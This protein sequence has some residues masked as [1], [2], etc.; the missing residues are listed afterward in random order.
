MRICSV[1]QSFYPYIGGVSSYLFHLAK[2]INKTDHNIQIVSLNFDDSPLNE[3]VHDINVIR[4]NYYHSTSNL[5]KG[6]ASFKEILLKAF[7]GV[8]PHNNIPVKNQPGFKEYVLLNNNIADTV[9]SLYN[10][11]SF[12]IIHVHD[13]QLLPLG[14]LL[15]NIPV[16]IIFT[17]H[18]PFLEITPKHWITFSINYLD[19]FDHIIVSSPNY[20]NTLLNNGLSSH[21]ITSITPFIPEEKAQP[22]KFSKK[23]DLVTSKI[24]ICVA[25]IDPL[26]G[27][28]TLIKSIPLV[29]KEIPNVKFV[30]IGNGS[31]TKEILNPNY[32]NMFEKTLKK[33]VSD[34]NITDSV[35]FTGA[36]SRDEVVNAFH[37]CDIVV[38]PSLAEG[39]GLSITEGMSFGKPVIGSNVGGIPLQ[40]KNGINGYLIKPGNHIQLAHLLIHLLK[41]DCLIDKF[42]TASYLNY[43]NNFNLEKGLNSILNLYRSTLHNY[44]D[45]FSP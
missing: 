34:L 10:D 21:K 28:D 32:K 44:S 31:L 37:D 38:L 20:M 29:I 26:K 39:F 17:W 12:D 42:G 36:L 23:Y 18:V 2:E 14:E 1:T 45:C 8:T 16:P 35:I 40:I 19:K 4:T 9:Y 7:H 24:I 6:Y 3:Y 25:R 11:S 5:V 33:L 41:N 22:G 15:Q 27:Q 30:L 13:F 43:K